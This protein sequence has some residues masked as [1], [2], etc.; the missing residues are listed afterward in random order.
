MV[1][2]IHMCYSNENHTR[3]S[4]FENNKMLT[5]IIFSF[6]KIEFQQFIEVQ[7]NCFEL[8]EMKSH[9]N[10]DKKRKKMK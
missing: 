6:N 7:Q 9:I 10:E 3:F 1:R 2:I 8:R 5:M 4:I